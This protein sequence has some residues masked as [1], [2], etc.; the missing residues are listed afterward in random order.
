MEKLKDTLSQ[1]Y[2]AF[3]V[4]FMYAPIVTL[5]ALSFN[6]GRSRAQWSGFTFDWYAEMWADQAIMAALRN[7][8]IIAFVSAFIATVL[9]TIAA[10]GINNMRSVSRNTVMSITNIPMLNADIVTGIS[11]MLCF[12]AFGVSLGFHTILIAHITFNLP[13]VILSV[14]PKV[15]QA[16]KD[17]YEAALDLGATPVQAFFKVVLP[18]LMPGV[19]SGFMLAFTMSLD[20]FIITHFTRGAGIDTISTLVYSQVRKGIKPTMYALSTVIFLTVFVVLMI[21][22]FAPEWLKKRRK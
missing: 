3:I 19:T 9:G 11:M 17:T 22:N 5:V 7:T 12:I 1:C 13:Y 18:E 14:M 10:I 4:L 20:D 16:S 15:R 8:I 6:N 21:G 2:L